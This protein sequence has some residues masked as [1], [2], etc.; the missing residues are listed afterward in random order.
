M[1][2]F[3]D[4]L[5]TEWLK[6]GKEW[7]VSK[8]FEFHSGEYNS[9]LF[10]RCHEGMVTD[11]ASIPRAIRWLIPKVGMDAQASVVHDRGYRDGFVRVRIDVCERQIAVSRG[12]IDSMYLQAMRALGV[13]RWRRHTLYIGVKVGGWVVWNRLRKQSGMSTETTT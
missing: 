5:H 12:M 4:R 11:L 13:S 9:G 10:I 7:R 8:S 2:V 1:S 3:T 6:G